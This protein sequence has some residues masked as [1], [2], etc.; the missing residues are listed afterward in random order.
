L[1]VYLVACAASFV[2]VLARAFQTKSIAGS[3]YAACY[4][5]SY[6]MCAADILVVGGIAKE[7]SVPMWLALSFGGSAGVCVAIYL[8]NH[9]FGRKTCRPT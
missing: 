2:S 6:L 5:N 1:T 4:V 7:Q 3:H 9:L 8:H